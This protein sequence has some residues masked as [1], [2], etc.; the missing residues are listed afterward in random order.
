VLGGAY[1]LRAVGDA[2]GDH[3]A[4]WI[5]WLS[6]IGWSQQVRPS[7]RS[8]GRTAAADRVRRGDGVRRIRAL[9]PAGPGCR[10]PRRPARLGGRRTVAVGPFGLAWRLQR[11]TLLA[12]ASAVAILGAV[13]GSI[14]TNIGDIIDNPEAEDFIATLGGTRVLTDAFLALEL[15]MIGSIVSVYGMQAAMRPRTEEQ[16]WRADL[17]LS[18]ATGR[19]RWLASHA[20]LAAAATAGV[21]LLGG[22]AAGLGYAASLGDASVVTGALAGAA[23]QIPAA[24]VMIGIVVAAFGLAPASRPRPGACWSR[25]C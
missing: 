4:L 21:L 18:T 15:G 19:V 2:A 14:V 12:W 8:G 23:V 17:V 22:L 11:G 20:V 7:R 24:F 1:I 3:D 10:P 25:S 13:V 9:G 6:P 16:A 5:S